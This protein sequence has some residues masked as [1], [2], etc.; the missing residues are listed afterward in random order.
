[1]RWIEYIVWLKTAKQQFW[2][3]RPANPNYFCSSFF[4]IWFSYWLA[5]IINFFGTIADRHPFHSQQTSNVMNYKPEKKLNRENIRSYI[6]VPF[7]F[8]LSRVNCSLCLSWWC[9][10]SRIYFQSVHENT[11]LNVLSIV[12][13]CISI[14]CLLVTMVIHIAYKR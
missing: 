6:S 5:L 4:L 8:E 14:M 1:M 2:L 7:D 9:F 12:S 10:K 3:L 11:V 13:C